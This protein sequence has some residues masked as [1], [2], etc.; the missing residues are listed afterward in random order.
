MS[1]PPVH[2]LS[3]ELTELLSADDARAAL[4]RALS[5]LAELGVKQVEPGSAGASL[6]VSAGSQVLSLTGCTRELSAV[7]T[8]LLRLALRRAVEQEEHKSTRERLQLLSE[9]SFEGILVHVNGVV[10]DVNQRLAEMVRC[11]PEELLGPDTI[12]RTTAPEDLEATKRRVASGYEG[13]YTIT[14]MRFDGTRFRAELQSKQGRLGDRPVRIA[15]V[16]DVTERERT[17]SLLQES[18][19]H[20]QDLA[21]GAFDFMCVSQR[22]ILVHVGGKVEELLGFTAAEMLGRHSL[23]FVASAGQVASSSAIEHNRPGAYETVLLSKSGEEIPAEVMGVHSTF[24]G[25]PARVAGFRDLRETRRQQAEHRKLE[26]QLQRSQRLDSL[27]VLAGGIA[28]D[29]NNLLVGVIGNASL[30]LATLS[31]PLDRQAAESIMAAGE[32][33]ATLT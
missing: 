21:L 1:L 5:R 23:D 12:Y 31:D 8:P 13:A 7:L 14:A 3:T 16:R 30:L 10:I 6:S 24:H 32:R 28:H 33:A 19:K 22:G 11:R 4:N 2:Q 20:L 26:L 27:G 9:A 29:F 18:E 17:L 25:E 15:A